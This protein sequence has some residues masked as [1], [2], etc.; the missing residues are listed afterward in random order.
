MIWKYF[1]DVDLIIG[2]EV[3]IEEKI[4]YSWKKFDRINV[5]NN[6]NF[7]FLCIL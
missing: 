6:M 7:I 5:G 2:Y 4:G 3:F 1:W